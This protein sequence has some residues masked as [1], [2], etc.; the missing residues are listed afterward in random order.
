MAKDRFWYIH[1]S[2]A[3]KSIFL[4]IAVGW[5]IGQL[6]LNFGKSKK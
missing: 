5:M 4:G 3:K 1:P 2:D 6:F